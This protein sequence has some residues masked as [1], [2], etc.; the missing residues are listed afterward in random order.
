M[1]A[2]EPTLQPIDGA[3]IAN[4]VSDLSGRDGG[5]DY[6]RVVFRPIP[7]KSIDLNHLNITPFETT[8]NMPLQITSLMENDAFVR[9]LEEMN[10]DLDR[11]LEED[12]KGSRLASE[13]MVGVTM[14]LSA[15]FVNWVLRAGS[16]MAGFMSMAPLWK[17]LDPLPI[18]GAS[19]IHR[20]KKSK[21]RDDE[22][23]DTHEV[24]EIF[25]Q[26]EVD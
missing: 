17:Q 22:S 24:E 26:E 6:Q 8:E 16:L 19:V 2:E 9:G 7:P 3:L 14:S 1:V 15:G 5:N 25:E 23:E 13:A 18:L 10:R 21:K 12:Q 11:E 20:S 4:V